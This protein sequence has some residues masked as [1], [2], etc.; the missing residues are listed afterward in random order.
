MEWWGNITRT[1]DGSAASTTLCGTLAELVVR[2][3]G[4]RLAT[5]ITLEFGTVQPLEVL[6]AFRLDAWAYN[7]VSSSHGL[8]GKA[9]AALAMRNAFYV[10]TPVWKESVIDQGMC[11]V[12]AAIEGLRRSALTSTTDR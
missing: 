9:Q 7:N 3:L 4:Q 1:D 8:R 5:S 10:E 11:T 2:E 12:N 6:A